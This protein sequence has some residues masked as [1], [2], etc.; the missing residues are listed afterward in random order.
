VE[1]WR[2][3]EHR[4]FVF[5]QH[6]IVVTPAGVVSGWRW[7]ETSRVI[8][9]TL[10]PAAFERFAL[11]EVGVVLDA[12]HLRSLP[13]FKDEDLCRAGE[14]LL[15][16]LRSRAVGSPLLYESMAR[17]FLIKLIQKYGAQ[18]DALAESRAS[19]TAE[20]YRRVLAYIDA[21]L[22]EEIAVDDLAREAAISPAHFSRLFKQVI[23]ETP[24][25]FVLSAR[26]ERAKRLLAD[27]ARPLSDVALACGF[28]DQAHFTR[29]FK[30]RAG[31]T[32]GDFRRRG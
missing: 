13:Q 24:H 30:Q 25:Q 23:G 2:D 12:A 27:A 3:G 6:E 4:D 7:H 26:V 11:A 14:L 5:Q 28:S 8:V 9:I 29:V 19:F 17:V 15:D 20:H 32:P 16:A 31:V 21:H 18:R 1:N 22:A 10:E